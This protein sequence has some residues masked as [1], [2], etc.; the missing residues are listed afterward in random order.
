MKKALLLTLAVLSASCSARQAGPNLLQ[1]TEL[2]A[3]EV[4]HG[5]KL[6][7]TGSGFPDGRIARVTFRGDVFRPGRAPERDVEVSVPARTV[8]PHRLEATISEEMVTALCGRDGA[9]HATF[10]GDAVAAFAPR[11]S[12]AA[13]VSGSL[14]GIV[15]DVEPSRQTEGERALALQEGHRFAEFL[16]V[17]VSHE[18]AGPLRILKVEPHGRG[19]EV[20]LAAG[21]VVEELS[22]VRITSVAD[23]VPPPR[24]RV[25]R[26]GM[27]RSG[28]EREALFAVEVAEFKP[29]TLSDLVPAF[30]LV[31]SA[32]LALLFLLSPLGRFATWL[33][34]SLVARS[35]EGRDANATRKPWRAVIRG[36]SSALPASVPGYFGVSVGSSLLAFGAFGIPLVA[37]ELDLPILLLASASALTVSG[38]LAESSRQGGKISLLKGLRRAWWVAVAQLPI[39]AALLVAVMDVGSLRA[40]DFAAAQQGAPWHFLAFASPAHFAALLLGIFALVPE[41]TL[42]STSTFAGRSSGRLPALAAVEWTHLVLVAGLLSVVLL[43]GFGV[44]WISELDRASSPALTALGATWLVLKTFGIVMLVS[45]LRWALGRINVEQCQTALVRVGLPMTLIL[46]VVTKLWTLGSGGPMLSAY[47][48]AVAVALF[49]ATAASGLLLARRL[50]QTL[51]VSRG[52]PSINPWL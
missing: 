14:E 44:P 39:T 43:G 1:V 37:R 21:D 31:G 2:S 47:R 35:R 42:A 32:L 38:F 50:G 29:G 5:D 25:A 36:L 24:A 15:L 10:R 30:A 3:R 7:I 8:T 19:A 23:F 40:D 46:P 18:G 11:K 52:E 49:V 22:G 20:G 34:L 26:L 12:G 9:S 45:L 41:A 6:E 4:G 28:V 51:R 16:G 48:G 33:E 27:H 13:P 17:T